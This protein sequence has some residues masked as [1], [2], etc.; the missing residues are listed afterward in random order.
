MTNAITFSHMPP[1]A[2]HICASLSTSPMAFVVRSS[3]SS[4]AAIAK[5]ASVYA[6][7]R[8]MAKYARLPVVSSRTG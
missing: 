8:V 6:S 3:T 5:T 4:V 1:S 2:A 7:T